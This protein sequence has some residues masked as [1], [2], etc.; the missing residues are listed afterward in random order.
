M[1]FICIHTYSHHRNSIDNT[2]K[3]NIRNK[4]Q[5]PIWHKHF[6]YGTYYYRNNYRWHQPF[7]K[8]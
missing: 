7:E 1:F 2:H 4:S 5:P 6:K 8:A 3:Q